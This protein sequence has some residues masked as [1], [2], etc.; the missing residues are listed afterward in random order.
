VVEEAKMAGGGSAMFN[1]HYDDG[2]YVQ[3]RRLDDK[4][5]YNPEG[6][7]IRFYQSGCFTN[8]AEEVEL[9]GNMR[10]VFVR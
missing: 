8:K 7:L 6:E 3:A 4:G 1:D 10:R 9:V 5:E 2:W